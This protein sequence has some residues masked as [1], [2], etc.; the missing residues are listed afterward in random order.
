MPYSV[1]VC[2]GLLYCVV[3]LSLVKINE[4]EEYITVI[5]LCDASLGLRY[6]RRWSTN[7]KHCKQIHN[8]NSPQSV[9]TAAN[10]YCMQ[11][12]GKGHTGT[13]HRHHNKKAAQTVWTLQMLAWITLG[14]VKNQ[15]FSH[16]SYYSHHTVVKLASVLLMDIRHLYTLG[17]HLK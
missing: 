2:T 17:I 7:D 6:I 11:V 5:C 9:W 10:R 16:S 4:K 12:A 3:V 15:C 14:F 13:P 8:T 1:I